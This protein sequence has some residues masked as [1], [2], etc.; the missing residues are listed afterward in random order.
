MAERQNVF[1]PQ[2]SDK[3]IESTKPVDVST[4][5]RKVPRISVAARAP[6]NLARLV[7][8]HR[9]THG[10]LR[11]ILVFAGEPYVFE[12]GRYTKV[13]PDQVKAIISRFIDQHVQLMDGKDVAAP[14]SWHTR[15]T[16]IAL[17]EQVMLPPDAHP[18]CWVGKGEPA[19]RDA[20][21]LTV[22]NG[23]LNPRTGESFK[24]DPRWF[25]LGGT[26]V[27]YEPE[28]NCPRWLA[29][30]DD[31][32]TD[33]PE[34]KDC[35]AEFMGATLMDES[36]LQKIL[37]L[38]GV[39]R[40]G[41]GTI[42]RIMAALLGPGGSTTLSLSQLC[43]NFGIQSIIGRRAVFIPDL[44]V[45]RKA[46]LQ[47]GVER[48]KSYSG[49]DSLSVPRKFLSDFEGPIRAQWW[50]AFNSLP[51]LSDNDGSGALASRFQL[52]LFTKS[53]AGREDPDL[54][55]ALLRELPGIL[56]F[57]LEGWRRLN[58]RGRFKTPES[59]QGLVE[60]NTKLNT[61]LSEFRDDCC[62][63]H[64]L[65]VSEK[66]DIY[67]AYVQWAKSK[68]RKP[69]SEPKFWNRLR[70][71]PDISEFRTF[72]D[73]EKTRVENGV[74]FW[75]SRKVRG[76]HIRG[77]KRRRL[78]GNTIVDVTCQKCGLPL[79]DGDGRCSHCGGYTGEENDAN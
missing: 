37:G 2:P 10:G 47:T 12:Q 27:V 7:I 8:Q 54:E 31:L 25:D 40:G 64:P 58:A 19:W 21:V 23:I 39:T 11:T 59:A 33:D 55:P 73:G 49:G 44:E 9:F 50:L 66:K 69:L 22:G 1:D 78:D 60:L 20:R 29:F 62:V 71:I 13:D 43:T 24:S 65:A 70:S 74:R 6:Q 51:E 34:S 75:P 26:Q 3:P 67:P 76:L 36:R 42:C 5:G 30:L 79:V 45:G 63:L 14:T 38:Y 41:K 72:D 48:L 77:I 52:I 28:A 15:E 68:D 46:D 16:F 32:W 4:T 17:R 35:L 61:A 53:F 56:L 18:P 57:A